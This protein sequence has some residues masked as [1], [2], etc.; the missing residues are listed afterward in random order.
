MARKEARE[1]G[2]RA[3]EGGRDRRGLPAVP[4]EGVEELSGPK[5]E[6]RAFG[7]RDGLQRNRGGGFGVRREI[8][9]EEEAEF[10][11]GAGEVLVLAAGGVVEGGEAG[12]NVYDAR[13]GTGLVALLSAGASAAAGLDAAEP[14]Q[15]G[16]IEA[17]RFLFRHGLWGDGEM[18]EAD[19]VAPENLVLF[20]VGEG[21]A[22]DFADAVL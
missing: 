22:E 8:H 2:G 6:A 5:C 9:G 12:F 14:E 20:G 1:M 16:V 10:V 4:L 15:R 18:E 17:E 11:E 21:G 7:A 19:G 3:A 13:G